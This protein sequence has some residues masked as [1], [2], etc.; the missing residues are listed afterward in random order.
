MTITAK[1]P[2]TCPTCG[3]HIHVGDKVEWAKGEK[4]RHTDCG[5][6]K[7]APATQPRP[8]NAATDKQLS[9]L[10]RMLSRLE[11]VQQFDSFGGN[12][13]SAAQ[14][15]RDDIRKLGGMDALTRAQASEM[16]DH[17]GGLL[18]DEM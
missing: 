6:A 16:L 10:R 17:V 11:R 7:S 14:H 13:S 15:V 18:D 12:G 5:A 2:G 1:F 9:A 3:N 4:A 8:A